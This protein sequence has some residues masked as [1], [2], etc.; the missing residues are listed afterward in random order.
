MVWMAHEGSGL[1]EGRRRNTIEPWQQ[2]KEE[3]KTVQRMLPTIQAEDTREV[4][5]GNGW[6]SVPFSML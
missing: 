1:E 2:T 4:D 6:P 3:D 5:K